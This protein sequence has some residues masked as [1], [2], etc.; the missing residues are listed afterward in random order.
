VF[1]TNHASNYL[2]LRGILSQNRQRLLE[3]IDTVLNNPQAV[4]KLRP[5]YIRGL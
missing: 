4:S 3:A 1:R 2:P 5:E